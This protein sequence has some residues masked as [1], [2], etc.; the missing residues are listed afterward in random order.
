MAGAVWDEEPRG[1]TSRA[2]AWR[3]KETR[4]LPPSNARA[5]PDLYFQKGL[6]MATTKNDNVTT[7]QGSRDHGTETWT[8]RKTAEVITSVRSWARR[9]DHRL[10]RG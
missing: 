9:S 4:S 1:M 6:I 10:H 3:C 7:H 8:V 2:V 5:E